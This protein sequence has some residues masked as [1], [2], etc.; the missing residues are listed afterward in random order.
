M[1]LTPL[2]I[3]LSTI[4]YGQEKKSVEALLIPSPLKIDGILN[5]EFYQQVLPA[6]DFMQLQPNNGDPSF[7]PSEV[8]FFYD[9][10]SIYVGAMLYD[11][12]PNKIYNYLSARD[13]IGMSDYFGVYFDPYNKGQLAY[14]FFIT[15]AG[16]QTDMKAIKAEFDKEDGNWDA[17]WQSKTRITEDGWVIEMRI[18]YSAL[19]FPDIEEHTWGLNM[20]RNIRRYNSNNSW[21][22]IDRR[23]SGFIHQQG[24]LKG[25]KNITPPLRLSL[26]PYLATYIE[27]E[28][29][30]SDSELIY[31]G[32]MDLKYGI[33]ESFTLD[34]ML[35][36]D[37]G[38]IQSDDKQ[39]N[40]SPF[41]LYYDEKR[42][43]FTEGTEL[44]QRGNIFYSRRIG[45]TPKFADKAEDELKN[46]EI[47]DYN[48]TTTRL[49]NATKVSGRT[50]KGWGFGFLN[51]MSLPSNA[52]LKDTI[53]GKKRN[54]LIQP[55]TNYN[56]FTIDK[57][58]KNNSYISF[59]NTNMSMANNPFL[60]NVIA[61]EFQLRDKSKK[62]AISGKGGF[63][64]RKESENENE[65]GGYAE[66]RLRKNN[67]KLHFGII[68][69]LYSENFNPNDMGY[70]RRSNTLTT[71]SY[72]EYHI[73]KPF[74]IFRELHTGIFWDY[75]RIFNPSDKLMHDIGYWISMLFKNNYRAN[76]N[77]GIGSDQN[78]YHETRVKGRYFKSPYH[79][80]SNI[81][82]RT[83]HRKKLSFNTHVGGYNHP[84]IKEYVYWIGF[85]SDIRIGQH[86]YFEYDF[87]IEDDIDETGYVE[88]TD[89]DKT[90]YFG[91]RN[92]HSL[93]NQLKVDYTFNNKLSVAFRGRH[94][95]SSVEY[96]EFYQL[97]LDGS[98]QIDDLYKENHDNN[99]NIFNI[100]M[101]LKWIFAPGSE[102]SV[103]WKNAIFEEDDYPIY[104]FNDN[105][106]R[107]FESNATNTFSLKVLYYIDYLT[108]KNKLKI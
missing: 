9:Q 29:G 25:I 92:V 76:F 55:F 41:E 84:S 69:R 68:E 4:I 3:L 51:A 5:E 6:K 65:S 26:T 12:S 58:L 45:G 28:R 44:F 21:S 74:N 67:G 75:D 23:V 73:F 1:K 95:W 53:T 86:I 14:G 81:N 107:I 100:D 16:V 83:D 63:S 7:Q 37:F 78:N 54:I 32:G 24:E 61:T 91:L 96:R 10:T 22:F 77:I 47:V 39:L 64:Y 66:L 59:I 31:K 82:L 108:L 42:Q 50:S 104:S 88:K 94:Y 72:I 34:M 33:N 49:A 99:L 93:E 105:L 43:F 79:I 102:L 17:V 71:N 80:W 56:T 48:P 19:R 101:I 40:L 35:I 106:S 8:Y 52:T 90:I 2:L 70:L 60:A 38:Q 85:G 30:D 89:D 46:H 98:L 13:N 62:F 15:P 20:F 27:T 11:N 18:P 103:S 97:Q 87:N 57:S 36:P